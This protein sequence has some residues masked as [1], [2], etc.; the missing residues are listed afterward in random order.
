DAAAFHGADPQGFFVK[1]IAGQPVAAISVVNHSTD[2]AFLG[3]Y[4]CR[5]EYRG[6]GFG[7]EIWRAGL[8]H[9][10]ARCVGLDGVP[11]QQANYVRSGFTKSGRTIRFQGS[12]PK[13]SVE[14]VQP[15]KP[16]DISALIK[17]DALATG[18]TRPA[19]SQHWFSNTD[20]RQTSLVFAGPRIVACA[21]T[22]ACV[23]GVKVGPLHAETAEQV[24]DLL[25]TAPRESA[26]SAITVDVPESCSALVEVLEGQGFACTQK[27]PQRRRN[28]L[29]T[30]LQ[31]WSL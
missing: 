21:T 11:E 3:L 17:A 13:N 4:L 23:D 9:A 25:C 16:S 14:H 24:L 2:F 5:P 30:Q 22:R 27:H 10:G 7:M 28:H 8:A 12:L 15:A 20:T 6:Q 18:I 19:F 1:E 31:P 26:D 29:C